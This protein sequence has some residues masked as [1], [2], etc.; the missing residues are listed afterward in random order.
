MNFSN[1]NCSVEVLSSI[2]P[3]E[4]PAKI[5]KAIL[6]ILPD[7]N[8][9]IDK[10]SIKAQSKNF[11]SLEKIHESIHSAKSQKALQRQL[12]QHMDK[13]STWFY[14]NKQAAFV[15]KVVLCENAEESPLGPL[16]ITI[17]SS[18]IDRIIDSLVGTQRN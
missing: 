7:S 13:D 5:E 1:Y 11:H 12:E 4:N 8:I 2:N 15:E 10:F 18:D 17:S 14:L 16:K 9:T 3:S 6:N